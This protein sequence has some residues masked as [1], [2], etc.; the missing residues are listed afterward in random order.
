M[1]RLRGSKMFFILPIPTNWFRKKKKTKPSNVPSNKIL[2]YNCA[3]VYVGHYSYGYI[4]FDERYDTYH[5]AMCD[6]KILK[7]QIST[8]KLK[9]VKVRGA[10]DEG[11]IKY[12]MLDTYIL[13][14][15]TDEAIVRINNGHRGQT[16][17]LVK[18]HSKRS[19]MFKLRL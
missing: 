9:P 8:K 17:K 14:P 12:H 18:S 6:Y 2:H 10:S 3:R 13:Y 7:G 1:D 16:I 4:A 5:D 19:T 11:A 15:I